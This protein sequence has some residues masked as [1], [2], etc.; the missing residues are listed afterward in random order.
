MV[1]LC[2]SADPGTERIIAA[3]CQ[4][5]A[6]EAY[7]LASFELQLTAKQ[8]L[9]EVFEQTPVFRRFVV[10]RRTEVGDRIRQL[11]QDGG[12]NPDNTVNWKFGCYRPVY[13]ATTGKLTSVAHISGDVVNVPVTCMVTNDWD[14]LKNEHDL[15]A[16]FVIEGMPA[17][18]VFDFVKKDKM[19]PMKVEHYHRKPRE[20]TTRATQLFAALAAE[21][22]ATS[23]PASSVASVAA[24]AISE[25][26]STTR[27]LNL[28]RA[29]E[30]AKKAA[31][32]EATASRLKMK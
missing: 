4:S 25:S 28:K 11:I 30:K 17:M 22:L 32:D 14:L 26:L 9:P 5:N 8:N 6:K 10:D 16:Q 13:D 18:I 15:S 31:E 19:G 24:T 3:V 20:L 21:R 29:R 12:I 2:H 7:K 23:M 1:T 27:S